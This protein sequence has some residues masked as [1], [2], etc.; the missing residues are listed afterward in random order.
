MNRA[1]LIIITFLSGFTANY[2]LV[3][4]FGVETFSSATQGYGIKS[5]IETRNK[6]LQVDEKVDRIDLILTTHFGEPINEVTEDITTSSDIL[7]E[8]SNS[9]G[10]SP[11]K[12]TLNQS[13]AQKE[14]IEETKENAS[15]EATPTK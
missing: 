11:E 1:S 2:L 5:Y 15:E 14:S 8:E 3:I 10:Y 6:I 12:T 13:E 9:K 4:F 7:S